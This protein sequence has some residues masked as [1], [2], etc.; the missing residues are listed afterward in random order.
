[1]KKSCYTFKIK[2]LF[3]LL[4]LSTSLIG[5]SQSNRPKT[6][7]DTIYVTY[8]GKDI[9]TSNYNPT[10]KVEEG[11]LVKGKKEA[12]WTKYY[13]DGKTPRLKGY[14]IADEPSGAYEKY[15]PTGAIKEKGVFFNHHYIDTLTFYFANGKISCISIYNK[16]GKQIGTTSHYYDTGNL[17]LTY[18][19]KDDKVQG[20][21]TW[22]TKSG[23]I[24]SQIIVKKP[25]HI[26]PILHNEVAFNANMPKIT[27]GFNAIRVAGPILKDGA[28]DPN[29]YN[30]IYTN[31]DELFQVGTF[32]Y[33]SIYN[34]KMYNYDNN[35]ILK[36]ISIYR[37]GFY[38]SEGNIQ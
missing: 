11:M 12:V 21:V 37:D 28:F 38:F 32:K 9:P 16:F 29:G 18:E 23:E 17:A 13:P 33:G 14:Y 1:M 27:N 3:I 35:G 20:E 31:Q 10:T 8:Y 25:G 4:N 24:S 2:A 34:G 15:Y 19:N 5:F 26:K 7:S 36:S 22:Y 6:V 30:V